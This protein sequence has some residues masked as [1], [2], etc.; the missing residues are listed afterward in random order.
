MTFK[1][2]QLAFF[3]RITPIDHVTYLG[4]TKFWSL[5]RCLPLEVAYPTDNIDFVTNILNIHVGNIGD[6]IFSFQLGVRRKQ[7]FDAISNISPT[8]NNLCNVK[9]G[10]RTICVLNNTPFYCLSSGPTWSWWL[11]YCSIKF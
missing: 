8:Q 2:V 5:L 6:G 10:S 7:Y 1:V 11:E 3:T 4:G 9:L